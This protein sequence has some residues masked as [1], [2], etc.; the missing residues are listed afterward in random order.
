MHTQETM[1][2][3]D[4]KETDSDSGRYDY[5]FIMNGD[6]KVVCDTLNSD[7]QEIHE[8][9]DENGI[10]SWDEQG[11]KDLTRLVE[12]RNAMIGVE[13]PAEFM[14]SVIELVNAIDDVPELNPSNYHH[15]D[16]ADCER[17]NGHMFA[18]WNRLRVVGGKAVS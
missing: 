10:Y 8:E 15:D 13:K 12:C 18:A 1:W 5:Y 9:Y 11:K 4:H 7:V 2:E 6:G 17:A 16:A 3:V 14:Q